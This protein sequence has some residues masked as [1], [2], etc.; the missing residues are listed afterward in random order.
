[1]SEGPANQEEPEKI[2]GLNVETVESLSPGEIEGIRQYHDKPDMT[3]GE[4]LEVYKKRMLW[5]L[6]RFRHECLRAI[7]SPDNR[8]AMAAAFEEH[9]P[10]YDVSHL[11]WDPMLMEEK[12]EIH[13]P[14][15]LLEVP[16][17]MPVQV[18]GHIREIFY[19]GNWVGKLIIE[20]SSHS[21]T[22]VQ[23]HIVDPPLW[24]KEPNSAGASV[25]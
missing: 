9:G 15:T 2:I 20:Q 22:E 25:K 24:H 11:G 23:F 3:M 4:V 13:R 14:K 10:E 12:A 6:E 5:E 18:G 21:P 19:D 16:N 8:A 1:M 7:V 17:G